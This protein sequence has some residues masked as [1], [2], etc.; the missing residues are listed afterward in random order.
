M[1]AAED[2]T[3]IAALQAALVAERS[4]LAAE[5]AAR[6]PLEAEMADQKAYAARLETLL[7]EMRRARFGPRSEKLHP[8]QLALALEEIETA[9]AEAKP[10]HEK[11]STPDKVAQ[12][13]AARRPKPDRALPAHLPRIEGSSNRRR[14]SGRHWSAIGPSDNGDAAAARWSGSARIDPAGSTS[15]RRSIAC[16]SPSARATPAQ[17]VGRASSRRR[18][19]LMRPADVRHCARTNGASMAHR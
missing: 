8:D 15:C 3:Q 16:W 2:I 5:R 18:A 19:H 6:L 17:R 9:I 11:R 14:G 13:D 4:A 1:P 7:R 10:G 12:V